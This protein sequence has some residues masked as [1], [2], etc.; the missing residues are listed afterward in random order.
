[1]AGKA[2]TDVSFVVPFDEVAAR[3]SPSLRDTAYGAALFLPVNSLDF[4]VS[5]FSVREHLI[6]WAAHFMPGYPSAVALECQS[7]AKQRRETTLTTNATL[8]GQTRWTC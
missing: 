8:G 6:S 2:W 3:P 5:A 7:S 4:F 1:M